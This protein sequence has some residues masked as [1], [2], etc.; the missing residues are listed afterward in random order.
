LKYSVDASVGGKLAQIGSRL[1][2]GAARKLADEFFEK[3]AKL[4]AEQ[5]SAAETDVDNET[6]IQKTS[7]SDQTSTTEGN[8]SNSSEPGKTSPEKGISL[9]IWL[10]GLAIALGVLLYAF[11]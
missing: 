3:F 4:A 2:D 10:S 11:F 9:P 7:T 8:V 1:I 5:S 6:V